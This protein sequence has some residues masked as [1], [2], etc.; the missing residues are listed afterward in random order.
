MSAKRYHRPGRALR[1]GEVAGDVQ[2]GRDRR[3]RL[4]GG[5]RQVPGAL[6][7]VVDELGEGRMAGAPC[8]FV[9]GQVDAR[10]EERMCEP[11][12]LA[13]S[14]DDSMGDSC[15]ERL[16]GARIAQRRHVSFADRRQEE[17]RRP[18]SCRNPTNPRA[19][20]LVQCL[21]HRERKT[22]IEL[23]REGTRNFE[24]VER[25]AARHLVDTEK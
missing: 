16:L 19:N 18:R 4:R 12:P 6:D 10:C 13:G 9:C 2:G 3:I 24:R 21:G 17:E 5:E 20:E 25:I 22:R 7:R 14:L 11:Q 23:V 8:R 1:E 15:L